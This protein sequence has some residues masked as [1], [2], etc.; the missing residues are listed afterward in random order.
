MKTLQEI[1]DE[2]PIKS[3][4]G[5]VHS[6][7]PVYESLLSPY[8][9]RTRCNVLEIGLFNGAS[10]IM[11]EKYFQG[12]VYGIDC[13]E[14]PHDGMADLRPLIESGIYN[15]SIGDAADPETIE[16]FYKG[17]K[18]DVIVEDAG[19]SLDQ[20][21]KIYKTMKPYLNDG[22]IYIIE[23]VQ[24]IDRDRE[25]FGYANVEIIDRRNIKGRYDDVLIIIK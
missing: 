19:H 22:S 14:T 1:W 8:R 23:D 25:F 3:D 10:L 20:Q 4:K 2:L 9:G 15:I 24:D 21:L 5:N 17:L 12:H 7:L 18:F 16:R 13:S 6:Y 11:W